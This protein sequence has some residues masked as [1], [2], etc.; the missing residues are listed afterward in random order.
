MDAPARVPSDDDIREMA[1][2]RVAFRTH[3]LAY[4]LVNALLVGAWW[5]GSGFAAPTFDDRGAYFW[6]VWSILGWGVGLAFHAWGVFGG[7]KDAVAR[8]EEKLRRRYGRT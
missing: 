5:V 2:A 8:E 4:V 6:P 3:A 7:G 1:E